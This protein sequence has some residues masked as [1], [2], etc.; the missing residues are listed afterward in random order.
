MVKLKGP[1]QSLS[2]S[3]TVAKTITYSSWK[4]RPYVRN[5]P[6][7]VD[8]KDPTQKSNRLLMEWLSQTWST[9]SQNDRSTWTPIAAAQ[10]MANYH[11]FIQENLIR[12]AY[13]AAPTRRFP[14]TE[15]G[16]P[17]TVFGDG[18]FVNGAPRALNTAVRFDVLNDAWGYC[19]F[20]GDNAGF[21]T[22]RNNLALF[23]T[24]QTTDFDIRWIRDLKPATYHAKVRPFTTDGVMGPAGIA[25][26]AIVTNV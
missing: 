10:N 19:L 1:L 15:T 14:P 18:P 20:L 13:F 8:P 22:S 21:T 5:K 16:T 26:D 3:G 9:L 4:G 25:R 23:A 6:Q 11:A 24:N 12:F 2:A 7:P 17:P